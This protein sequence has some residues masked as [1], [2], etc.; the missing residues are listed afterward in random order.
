VLLLVILAA[1][2]VLRLQGVPYGLP[3]VTNSDELPIVMNAARISAGGDLN[4]HFFNYPSLYIYLEALNFKLTY[5]LGDYA[6]MGQMQR[7]DLLTAGR[8]LTVLMGCATV[9]FCFLTA[10]VLWGSLA[11]LVAA[12]LIGFNYLHITNSYL[13]AVDVPGACLVSAALW[14]AARRH[15]HGPHW[16]NYIA[17]GILAGLAMGTK[18]T[19]LFAFLPLLAA[20]FLGKGRPPSIWPGIRDP[21]LLVSAA[22]VPVAF[23]ISSPYVLLDMQAF[24]AAIQVESQHY[25]QGHAGSETGGMSYGAYLGIL[26]KQY[27]IPGLFLAVFG[28]MSLFSND[29]RSLGLMLVFP[30]VYFL[31]I[32]RYPVFFGRNLLPM[33]PFLAVLGGAAIAI[34]WKKIS[35]TGNRKAS[36]WGGAAMV[37]LITMAVVPQTVLAARHIHA[38]TLPDTRWQ[39]TLWAAENLPY[40][41]RILVEPHTPSIGQIT[42]DQGTGTR[43]RVRAL[44]WSVSDLSP[45]KIAQFDYLVVSSGMY[46]RFINAPQRYPKQAARYQEIFDRHRLVKTF[47]ADNTTLSG[48]EI[49]F[50]RIQRNPGTPA[51]AP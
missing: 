25:A 49:R 47:L 30:V 12:L 21:R 35:Q 20:H 34:T 46:G 6:T 24:W 13:I 17:G 50:Y 5:L 45:D 44:R 19:L 41:A 3:I 31:F 48:P 40:G 43:F 2:C 15:R 1:A 8:L 16:S 39:A 36:A 37:L 42:N 23:L 29:R 28:G 51:P 26:I 4:P 22:L 38:I 9:L 11:G 33:L 7:P 18:Y 27:G 32:G 10:R 14:L